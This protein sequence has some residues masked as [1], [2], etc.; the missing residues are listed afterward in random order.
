[1]KNFNIG[2][3]VVFVKAIVDNLPHLKG[4]Y[5]IMSKEK[6]KDKEMVSLLKDDD[7][8]IIKIAVDCVTSEEQ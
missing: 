6:V 7:D 5:K 8:L 1:M 4:K 3:Y 2:D